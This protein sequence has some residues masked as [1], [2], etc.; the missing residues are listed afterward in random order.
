M[1]SHLSILFVSPD[2]RIPKKETCSK[3]LS[4]ECSLYQTIVSAR[5]NLVKQGIP[6]EMN[7]PPHIEVMRTHESKRP[8]AE[9]ISCER[10]R[11][12]HGKVFHATYDFM[13]GGDGVGKA[14][15]LP[16]GPIRG[17]EETHA[18]IAYFP[19]GLDRDLEERVWYALGV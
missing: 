14:L 4:E 18:T 13:D 7:R 10:A 3:L 6:C 19:R 12:L 2:A 8:D 11:Q 17:R 1:S 15:V 9:T 5:R 16:T